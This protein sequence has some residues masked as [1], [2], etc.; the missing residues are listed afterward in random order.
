MALA[1][2]ILA[3]HTPLMLTSHFFLSSSNLDFFF[4]PRKNCLEYDY[5][6]GDLNC[7]LPDKRH[8][9]NLAQQLIFSV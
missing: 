9:E 3:A 5:R 4:D 7:R 2:M 8:L 6:A 1:L